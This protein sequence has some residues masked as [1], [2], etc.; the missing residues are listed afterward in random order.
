MIYLGTVQAKS[1]EAFICKTL[2]FQ[3]LIDN[4]MVFLSLDSAAENTTDLETHQFNIIQFAEDNIYASYMHIIPHTYSVIHT[5]ASMCM[6]ACMC[7]RAYMCMRAC[8]CMHAC[9][10][11]CLR[12]HKY[13]I[14][15][16]IEMP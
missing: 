10:R 6:H 7:M 12:R 14:N 8:M 16:R 2:I 15:S 5:C 1:N 9:M 4:I 13:R 3:L 11:I